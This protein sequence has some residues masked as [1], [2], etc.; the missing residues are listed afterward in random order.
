MAPLAEN[1]HAVEK[2]MQ[3]ANDPIDQRRVE[4]LQK[5]KVERWRA[6]SEFPL[7]VASLAMQLRMFVKLYDEIKSE[8]SNHSSSWEFS[9]CDEYMNYIEQMIRSEYL[10]IFGEPMAG[11]PPEIK[12]MEG[13]PHRTVGEESFSEQSD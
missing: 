12:Q 10:K 9:Q 13:K 2:I 7:R 1:N 11:Q 4:V 8:D 6:V 3:R 5:F